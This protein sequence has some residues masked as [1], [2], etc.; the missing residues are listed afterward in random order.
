MLH[1]LAL[2]TRLPYRRLTMRRS[3]FG[4]LLLAMMGCTDPAARTPE[5]R[6]TAPAIV[7]PPPSSSADASA[8]MASTAPSA[9]ASASAAP[10]ESDAASET[11]REPIMLAPGKSCI[12][13]LHRASPADFDELTVEPGADCVAQTLF[14]L[15][16]EIA[17]DTQQRF[18][19]QG[20]MR[21]N[22]SLKEDDLS[23]QDVDFDGNVDIEML[24]HQ[25]MGAGDYNSLVAVWLYVPKSRSFVRNAAFDRLPNPRVDPQKKIITWGG[26]LTGV[27][28]IDGH[29][30]WINGRL[31]VLEQVEGSSGETSDGKPLPPNQRWETRK[32]RKGNRLVTVFN[33]PVGVP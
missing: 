27:H 10:H 17:A 22:M 19:H 31:E 4:A 12:I 28:Y 6:E 21:Y 30:G 18:E 26:R 11:V 32:A 2:P 9:S 20:L 29:S 23:F 13:V 8:P 33:G 25:G 7:V 15:H 5:T 16:A 3:S 14:D 1:T 24:R